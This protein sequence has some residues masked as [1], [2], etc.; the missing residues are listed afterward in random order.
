MDQFNRRAFIAT[1]AAAASASSLSAGFQEPL[2]VQLYTVR[3]E[4]AK[5]PK[6]TLEA[7]RRIGYAYVEPSRPQMLKIEPLCKDLGLKTP[8]GH[9]EAP[10]VTGNFAPWKAALAG[11]VPPGYD[12]K[13]AV[14][15][16]RGWGMKYMVISYLMKSE[17]DAPGFYEKFCDQMNQAGE[18]ARK[19]GVTLCY[20]HHSFEFE[21]VNG[22]RAIDTMIARFDPNLVMFQI[23]TFWVKAG[24]DDPPAVIGKLK[25]RVALVHLKDVQSADFREYQESKVPPNMFREC[26]SGVLD[27]P[28]IL[29][30][31]KNAGVAGYIVEQDQ[32]P[33]SPIESLAKSYKYLRS[34]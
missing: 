28:A 1:T 15:Q 6:S 29:N 9:F 16:A 7:I 14:E 27:F 19:A 22:R 17:R 25:G 8:A 13:K 21:P 33:A 5:D 18:T 20:H 12:W 3:N 34:L 24:G 26:G 4:L 11:A 23:D 2:N 10:L 32:C 31:C 30:A